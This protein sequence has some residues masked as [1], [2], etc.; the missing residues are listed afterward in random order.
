LPA[1]LTIDLQYPQAAFLYRA[2]T[3]K[4]RIDGV[5]QPVEGWGRQQ[6]HLPWGRTAWRS[7]CRARC[8]AK[9]GRRL[10]M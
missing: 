6:F 10:S 3:P 7:T 1:T 8:P 9:R 4:V 5:E 2:T